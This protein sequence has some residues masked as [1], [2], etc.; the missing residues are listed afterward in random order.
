[1]EIYSNYRLSASALALGYFLV[2][3]PKQLII[4]FHVRFVVQIITCYQRVCV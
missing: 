1:M 3:I 4:E 2:I